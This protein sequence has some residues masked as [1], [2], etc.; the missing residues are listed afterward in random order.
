MTLADLKARLDLFSPAQIEFVATVVSSLSNPPS[1]DIRSPGTWLT[2]VGAWIEYFGLALSV[3][4]SATTEPLGLTAFESVF[5]NACQHV[6]WAVDPL[7]SPTR[8]F[9]DLIVQPASGPKRRLSL[10]ST[11]AAR[12]SETSAHISKLTEAAWIQ[13]ERTATGRRNR[14]LELFREYQA[15]VT[16]IIILRAFRAGPATTPNRYQLLEIPAT[17]FDAVQTA[18]LPVFERDAPLINC[19]AGDELAAI[20]A[21]DRSDAKITIRRIQLSV[22]TV[23]A[24]WR[25]ELPTAS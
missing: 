21:L 19:K 11:A 18:P 9:V 3:H 22:C 2:S 8:R 20:V 25:R 15:A 1:A 4:H 7:G 23:H 14:T 24:E 12:L 10:K 13:D 17:I 5:R 6:G 16:A